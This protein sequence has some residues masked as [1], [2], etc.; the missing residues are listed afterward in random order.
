MKLLCFFVLVSERI[1]KITISKTLE[2]GSSS[3]LLGL[4]TNWLRRIFFMLTLVRLWA[5]F[6][7]RKCDVFL[8][9]HIWP[10]NR[11]CHPRPYRSNNWRTG[12]KNKTWVSCSQGSFNSWF[13]SVS[14]AY[15]ERQ[16]FPPFPLL[17]KCSFFLIWYYT[18]KRSDNWAW[19]RSK[20][21]WNLFWSAHPWA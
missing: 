8:H 4:V 19:G 7:S 5:Y 2:E 11:K 10:Q 12:K 20:W 6:H 14:Q 18:I 13:L 16:D 15:S 17:E 9:P 21:C 1:D 3:N